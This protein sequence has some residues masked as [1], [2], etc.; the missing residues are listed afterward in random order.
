MEKIWWK[1]VSVPASEF[2]QLPKDAVL[3]GM[4]RTEDESFLEYAVPASALEIRS[5][6]C[7]ADY[8]LDGWKVAHDELYR[9]RVAEADAEMTSL[10]SALERSRKRRQERTQ[11]A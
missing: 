6:E 9:A 11:L 10:E 4:D 5:Q 2:M 1:M 8:D 7:L 3:L